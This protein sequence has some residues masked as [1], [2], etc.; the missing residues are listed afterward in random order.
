[1]VRIALV[2]LALGLGVVES[3]FGE[4]TYEETSSG[5]G[6]RKLEIAA[7][8]DYSSGHYGVDIPTHVV[9]FPINLRYVAEDWNLQLTL[10]YLRITGPGDV[11]GE[12]NVLAVSTTK[13]YIS[14][15]GDAV[16]SYSRNL[17]TS[18]DGQR[19]LDL[20]GRI[21]FGTADADEGMGTGKNDYSLQADL[22]VGQGSWAWYGSLGYRQMGDTD[23]VN[24]LNPWFASL[25][26]SYMPGERLQ[27][28]LTYD[29]RQKAVANGAEVREVT[30]SAAYP[31]TR[32]HT[33]Q[34]YAVRGF[35]DGSPEW[36][37]GILLKTA[38]DF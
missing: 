31:L 38:F 37:G 8:V 10:P 11:V 27:L 4:S 20:T 32:S 7:G 36:G 25:G 15:Q 18:E 9:Y 2:L 17:F 12:N 13:R 5:E 26:A 33:L 28:G 23:T 34:V 29:A 24:F 35:S 30:L 16:A 19:L 3:A 14:G 1:M 6:G 22:L 21:K